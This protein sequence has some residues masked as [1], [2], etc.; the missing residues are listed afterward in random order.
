MSVLVWIIFGALAGWIASLLVR[1]NRQRAAT[2][3]VLGILGAVLGGWFVEQVGTSQAT[4]LSI[5]SVLVAVIGATA[6]LFGY[7]ALSANRRT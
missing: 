5:Y 6:L 4:G 1:A 7:Q 3:V 2:N